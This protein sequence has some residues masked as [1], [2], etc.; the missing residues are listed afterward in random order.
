MDTSKITDEVFDLILSSI[1]TKTIDSSSFMILIIKVMEFVEKYKSLSGQEKTQV[2]IHVL[3]KL[4]ELPV[5]QSNIPPNV[6][7][8]LKLLLENDDKITTII[9]SLVDASKGKINV[10]KSGN[11]FSCFYK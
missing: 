1:S 5:S 4:L 3:K 10:N 9:V 2:V 8:I 11:C 7:T 6:Y